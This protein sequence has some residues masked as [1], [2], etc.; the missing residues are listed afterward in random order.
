[1]QRNKKTFLSEQEIEEND[2]MER[3]EITSRKLEIPREHL[4]DRN[5]KDL[6][7][8]EEI[9]KKCQEYTANYIFKKVLMTQI[10]IMV[11]SFT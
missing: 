9:K 1:M 6:R 10:T 3:L 11:W 5:G 7:E 2:R 8:A 4:K